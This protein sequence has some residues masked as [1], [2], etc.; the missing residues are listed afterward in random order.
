MLKAWTTSATVPVGNNNITI[1]RTTEISAE[2]KRNYSMPIYT[3]NKTTSNNPYKW[4]IL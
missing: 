4:L 1:K 2:P 3:N